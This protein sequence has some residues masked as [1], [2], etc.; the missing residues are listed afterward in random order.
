MCRDVGLLH[1]QDEADSKKNE[2]EN[3]KD[4]KSD[5]KL[6]QRHKILT[7]SENTEMSKQLKLMTSQPT[8]SELN[9]SSVD[10]R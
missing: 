5:W 2:K 8:E 10:D 4:I 6:N 1:R 9:T 7:A 3:R